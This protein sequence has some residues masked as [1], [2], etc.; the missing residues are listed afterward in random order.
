MNRYG[1]MIIGFALALGGCSSA[2]ETMGLNKKAPDEFKV[3]K[4]APLELPPEYALRPPRPG[5]PRP[6]EMD[7]ASKAAQTVFGS[8]EQHSQV[9]SNSASALLQQA[10]ANSADPSIRSTLD[11]EVEE[12]NETNKT[13]SQKLL[14]VTGLGGKNDPASVVDA[15][16]EAERLK[17]NAEAGKTVTDGETPVIEE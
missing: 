11:Q 8:Q 4:R 13:V 14:G 15:K 5:A 12:L 1:L 2:R 9:P 6:Q 17:E 3:L 7:T 10:G 16:K